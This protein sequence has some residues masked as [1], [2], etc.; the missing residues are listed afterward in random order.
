VLFR[1][2][3]LP[4]IR[5]GE[6]TVAFRRWKRPTVRAGGTLQT[7][8]GV[9]A[10]DAVDRIEAADITDD[11]LRS[12]GFTHRADLLAALRPEGELH[13]VA[14]HLAGPDPRIALR[15]RADLD[16]ED[17]AAIAARL[18]RFDAAGR[19]GP[20]TA[21]TLALIAAHPGRRA[22]DLAAEVGRERLAFK[23]DVRRLKALGLPESLEVGYRLSPRGEAF[24]RG[25]QDSSA[26]RRSAAR[27]HASG[28][29][30]SASRR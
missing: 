17:R 27:S 4:R 15:A 1:A 19:D 2:A 5:R 11:D 18:A 9:L 26:S 29:G 21:A 3:D 7:A 12:A 8:V 22:A 13:R 6:I 28:V 23:A 10:I 14:F 20:W 24:L 30:T 16:A 25:D